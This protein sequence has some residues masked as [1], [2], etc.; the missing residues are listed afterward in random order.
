MAGECG[1]VEVRRVVVMGGGV[2]GYAWLCVECEWRFYRDDARENVRRKL[3]EAHDALRAMVKAQ[4]L[5]AR[6]DAEEKWSRE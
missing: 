2:E 5:L 6:L 3:K 1:H 4:G